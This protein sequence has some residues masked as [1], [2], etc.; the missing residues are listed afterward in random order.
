[1]PLFSF[2]GSLR[3]A[4]QTGSYGAKSNRQVL[5]FRSLM[6]VIQICAH[7]GMDEPSTI[8]IYLP[9]RTN[10]DVGIRDPVCRMNSTMMWDERYDQ[11]EYVFG[12]EP[13]AFLRYCASLL[14]PGQKALAV[15]DGEGRNGVWLAHRGLDVTG[16]TRRRWV[17]TRRDGLRQGH[18]VEVDYRLA[19]DGRLGVGA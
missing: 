19:I 3:R 18:G 14:R 4:L 11:E 17:S 7:S 8:P 9:G 13:N 12:T 6:A 16:S 1:M 5:G 2:E 10:H 15:A